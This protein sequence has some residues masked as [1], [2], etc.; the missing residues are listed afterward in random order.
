MARWKDEELRMQGEGR[1]R[2]GVCVKKGR[3][4]KGELCQALE[5][6]VRSRS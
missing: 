1:G 4:S 5:G 3:V 2:V 6:K